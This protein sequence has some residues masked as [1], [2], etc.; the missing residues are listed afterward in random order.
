M[1]NHWDDDPFFYRRH[2]PHFTPDDAPYFITFR[3]AGSLPISVIKQQAEE[4]LRILQLTK[5]P[6][7]DREALRIAENRLFELYDSHLD[8]ALTGPTWLRKPE[9]AAAV[10]A[11]ILSLEEEGLIKVHCFTIM[12]NHVHI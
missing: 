8:R 4:R 7:A 10:K 12:S 5:Q 6:N 3:L 9:I 1:P 11:K 2:L